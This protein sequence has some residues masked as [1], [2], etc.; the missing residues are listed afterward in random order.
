MTV[1]DFE[2]G[3]SCIRTSKTLDKF[4]LTDGSNKDEMPCSTLPTQGLILCPPSEESKWFHSNLICVE[5]GTTWMEVRTLDRHN[6][7]KST[8]DAWFGYI[9]PYLRS[10]MATL[11]SWGRPA[12]VQY[13]LTASESQV[14]YTQLP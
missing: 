10:C 9:K 2:R 7:V 14:L 4:S 3:K 11:Q 5:D 6:K 8:R 13:R 1:E 12:K